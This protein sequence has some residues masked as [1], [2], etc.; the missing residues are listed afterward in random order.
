MTAA[1]A[2]YL[3]V[4]PDAKGRFRPRAILGALPAPKVAPTPPTQIIEPSP[5][6]IRSQKI[7]GLQ[8]ELDSYS[9]R[10]ALMG[11]D[12]GSGSDAQVR[13]E[14]QQ[15]IGEVRAKIQAAKG[16]AKPLSPTASPKSPVPPAPAAGN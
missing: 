8:M 13:K 3:A 1:T 10:L 4:M 9:A 14:L 6:L 5:E 15:K 11:P 16:G 7:A 12:K 2:A